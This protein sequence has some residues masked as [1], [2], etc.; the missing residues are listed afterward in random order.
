M[1]SDIQ[2]SASSHRTHPVPFSTGS[3]I[4][5]LLTNNTNTETVPNNNPGRRLPKPNTIQVRHPKEAI[6]NTVT[7]LGLDY[8][9]YIV[10]TNKP[11]TTLDTASTGPSLTDFFVMS[12][13]ILMKNRKKPPPS[14]RATNNN[15]KSKAFVPNGRS[16][17]SL[18]AYPLSPFLHFF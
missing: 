2:R 16:I 17:H 1:S 11:G 12:L 14:T 4:V 13:S 9:P 18:M 15:S 6:A 8:L 3:A 7:D 10:R 5:E